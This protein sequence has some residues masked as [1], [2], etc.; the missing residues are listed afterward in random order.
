MQISA[1]RDGLVGGLKPNVALG[2][3]YLCGKPSAMRFDARLADAQPDS[4]AQLFVVKKGSNNIA[5]FSLQKPPP[6]SV[7]LFSWHATEVQFRFILY[8]SLG[9]FSLTTVTLRWQASI[10]ILLSTTGQHTRS[11]IL[12]E[13]TMAISA[14]HV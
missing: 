3:A 7:T 10:G 14:V 8:I 11:S 9:R 2:W 5:S 12:P 4:H 6:W 13:S 1:L